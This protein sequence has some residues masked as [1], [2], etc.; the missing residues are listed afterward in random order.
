[1]CQQSTTS[2]SV[3]A[4]DSRDVKGKISFVGLRAWFTLTLWTKM[5][6]PSKARNKGISLASQKTEDSQ[7]EGCCVYVFV[8]HLN[9]AKFLAS[10]ST[11]GDY[12]LSLD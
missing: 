2:R 8:V 5:V 12:S 11:C 3:I 7:K 1:M 9:H 10:S 4:Y 6:F